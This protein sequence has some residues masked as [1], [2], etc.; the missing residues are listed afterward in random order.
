MKIRPSVH[1]YTSMTKRDPRIKDKNINRREFLKD[2]FKETLA[3][4]FLFSLFPRHISYF[5]TDLTTQL[6][7]RVFKDNTIIYT[8]PSFSSSTKYILKTNQVLSLS[9]E[10]IGDAINAHS[11]L[12]YEVENFGYI[13][14]N[15]VQPVHQRLNQPKNNINN[16]G[17][18]GTISVPYTKAWQQK[19]NTIK[20]DYLLFYYGSTHWVTGLYT[21]AKGDIYYK[22]REDRWGNS[23]Y[24]QAEHVEIIS[25]TEL[26]PFATQVPA[27]EKALEV[28]IADQ[29]VIA[30]EYGKAVFFSQASTGLFGNRLDFST[31]TGDY[32]INY[33]RPSR[34]MVHTDK[35]GN[36][37]SD[38]Y[39][40]PWV[41]YFTDSGIAFHGTYWHNDFGTPHSHGCIN[42]PI[43][44]AKWIYLWSQPTVPAGEEKF[45]SRSGTQVKV[46]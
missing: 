18:L 36:N 41:S 21:D 3:G 9:G 10:V 39:G 28:N 6:L 44:A 19:N 24:V 13:P 45:V 26:A 16:K 30:Y 12:W 34:H 43:Q 40:V 23:Y 37:D 4:F 38:L 29:S 46:I 15:S 42:L 2:I 5:E 32:Q 7:G 27:E 17:E 35:V 31:P 33:K 22:I 25:K 11:K 1:M 8:K 20:E 14:A